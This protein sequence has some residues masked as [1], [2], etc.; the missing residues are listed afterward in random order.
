MLGDI[1]ALD[2]F[3][4]AAVKRALNQRVVVHRVNLVPSKR[5]R[6]WI[7]ETDVRPV[8]VKRFFSG[9][10]GN[11]F[12]N[13][14]RAR[15]AGLEVPLPLFYEGDYLVLEFIPGENCE[16]LINHMFSYP[17]AKGMGAWLAKFHKALMQGQAHTVMVDAVMSNF[18]L[19]EGS[20]VYGVDLEDATRGE[21]LDDLGDAVASILG[22]EPFFTPIKFDLAINMIR[23]YE[24]VSGLTV[25]E[26]VR[27][28]VADHLRRDAT[29]KPLFRRTLKAAARSIE[30]EWPK[31]E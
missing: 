17:A 14:L 28:F 11:E 12:E 10:G 8:V 2:P 30:R 15:Q 4:W 26:K 25:M 20:S 19:S 29:S 31:L 5:N 6:V 23:S 21:P 16:I 18:I 22:S 13:L 7:V 3:A 24:E 9:R 27:P 1:T